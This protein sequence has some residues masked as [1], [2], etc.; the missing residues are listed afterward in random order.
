M[1]LHRIKTIIVQAEGRYYKAVMRKSIEDFARFRDDIIG[2]VLPA[3]ILLTIAIV[4]FNYLLSGYLFRPFNRILNQM[5]GYQAGQGMAIEQEST[6]TREFSR[7]QQLFH[8]MI[9]RIE[10]DY[11]NLK[12]YTENMA[13]ELQT[14]W[15]SFGTKLKT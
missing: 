1:H 11:K 9:E 13:H 4:L 5:K 7:M 6:S 15:Q 12:E 2:S 10:H 8:R 3:F 14:L